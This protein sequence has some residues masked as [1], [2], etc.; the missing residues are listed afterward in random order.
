M[1]GSASGKESKG[2]SPQS[3]D[4]QK[5]SDYSCGPY[6][7]NKSV[8][9]VPTDITFTDYSAMMQGAMKGVTPQSQGMTSTQ[10]QQECAQ[11]NQVPAGQMRNQCLSS[12]KCQ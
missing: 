6:A 4:V 10:K 12:L 3:A 1:M 5:Q 11:C 9:T 8:F 2:S 7:A